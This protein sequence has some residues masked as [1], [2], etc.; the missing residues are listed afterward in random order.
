MGNRFDDVQ[1][2]KA[3]ELGD[4]Y[5]LAK[6]PVNSFTIH[7]IAIDIGFGSSN[8]AVVATKFL[9][10]ESKMRVVFSQEWEHGDP[11]AI[12]NL[13]FRQSYIIFVATGCINIQMDGSYR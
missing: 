5:S 8:T 2:L 7:S 11:Q 1:I 4:K 10:E 12:V 3:I 6:I 9:K 13:I